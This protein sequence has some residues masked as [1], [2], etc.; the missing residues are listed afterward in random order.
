M[1]G[2]PNNRKPDEAASRPPAAENQRLKLF[3]DH[4]DPTHREFLRAG[5]ARVVRAVRPGY[6]EERVSLLDQ[7]QLGLLDAGNRFKK[8]IDAPLPPHPQGRTCART[9]LAGSFTVQ[10]WGAGYR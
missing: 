6:E 7:G 10:R 1:A 4:P 2:P 3:L 8:V 5:A 9:F